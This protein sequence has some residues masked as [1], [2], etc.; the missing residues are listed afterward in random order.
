MLCQAVE[1]FPEQADRLIELAQSA[2]QA[3]W[4]KGL[5]LK[6]NGICHGISGNGY[7]LHTLYRF[8]DERALREQNEP[9]KQELVRL[10]QMW[11]T[12]A[13]SFARAVYLPEV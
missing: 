12:R 2:G 3:T 13:F 11:R 10:S 4:E 7:M 5:I 9:K 1:L 6:G 8:F